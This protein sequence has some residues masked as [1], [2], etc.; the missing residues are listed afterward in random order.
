MLTSS[1]GAAALGAHA[2]KQ[3]SEKPTWASAYRLLGVRV[4]EA[5][6]EKGQVVLPRDSTEAVQVRNGKQITVTVFS[7]GNLEFAGVGLVVHVPA[8]DDGAEA[9]TLFSNGK[10][11]LFRNDFAT[12]HAVDIYTSQLYSCIIFE[13]LRQL[14]GRQCGALR[15]DVVG[16]WV[17][18]ERKLVAAV[19]CVCS[20]RQCRIRNKETEFV[21]SS[22]IEQE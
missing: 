12:E 7:I 8:K 14:G 1:H 19:R 15:H 2:I 6:K 13:Q 5:D 3:R 9:E 20:Q 10:K 16:F 11:L 22:A 4:E 18:V 17:W 21:D